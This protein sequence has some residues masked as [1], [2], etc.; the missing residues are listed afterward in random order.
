MIALS[1]SLFLPCSNSVDDLWNMTNTFD[2]ASTNFSIQNQS[3]AA[4]VTTIMSQ[5]N[6][7]GFIYTAV[8]VSSIEPQTDTTLENGTT[9][10]ENSTTAEPM[11]YLDSKSTNYNTSSSWIVTKN[12]SQSIYTA[13]P[14]SVTA[15]SLETSILTTLSPT[16]KTVESTYIIGSKT[17]AAGSIY[18]ALGTS[19]GTIS[20]FNASSTTEPRVTT[21]LVS[22]FD[23][24]ATI[25][26][27]T[28]K[29]QSNL[30]IST[31]NQDPR[32]KSSPFCCQLKVD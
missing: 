5:T 22:L 17:P 14:A 8:S 2:T 18:T 10:Q 11:S 12:T 28:S 29:R 20:T 15:I 25:F 13:A 30:P 16:Y 31:T 3:G 23:I 19:L 1:L 6:G 9:F 4:D 27:T 32:T 7:A 26:Q 21:A 24:S